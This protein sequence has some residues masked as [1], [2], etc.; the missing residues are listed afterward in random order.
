MHSAP[1]SNLASVANKFQDCPASNFDSFETCKENLCGIQDE[2]FDGRFESSQVRRRVWMPNMNEAGDGRIGSGHPMRYEFN[3]PLGDFDDRL[4]HHQ[5]QYPPSLHQHSGGGL[6]RR[7]AS[8]NRIR[9][10]AY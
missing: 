10:G 2:D 4:Q 5:Q 3:G 1:F 6:M 8:R 9:R 7:G